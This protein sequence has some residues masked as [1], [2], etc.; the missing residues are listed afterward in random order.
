MS[1]PPKTPFILFSL[2]IIILSVLAFPIVKSRYFTAEQKDEASEIISETMPPESLDE[3]NPAEFEDEAINLEEENET[4]GI[5]EDSEDE[6]INEEDL[7]DEIIVE[8][9]SFLEILSSDCKNGCKDFDKDEDIQYCKQ[10]CGLVSTP[11]IANGCDKFKD[12]ERDYCFKEEAIQKRDGKI[13]N[14]IQDDGIKKSCFN[15]ITEDILDAPQ[16]SSVK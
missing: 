12:L 6:G 3:T 5:S 10:Y 9:N 4:E 13:C 8:D 1:L 2:A 14:E 11:K 16:S 15:R 7:N